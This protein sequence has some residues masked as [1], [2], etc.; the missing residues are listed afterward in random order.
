L[1][2]LNISALDPPLE[3]RC[4]VKMEIY[5]CPFQAL[6]DTGANKSF[7]WTSGLNLVKSWGLLINRI[8]DF[9]SVRLANG[10]TVEVQGYV[11]LPITL[12]RDVHALRFFPP[13]T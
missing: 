9:S 5:G 2:F 7:L 1:R 13:I 12:C 4:F 11:D 6:V 10:T 3:D 8:S